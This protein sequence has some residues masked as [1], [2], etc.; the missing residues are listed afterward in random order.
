MSPLTAPVVWRATSGA[1]SPSA[2]GVIVLH[3]TTTQAKASAKA[4]SA[5]KRKREKSAII[6]ATAAMAAMPAATVRTASGAGSRN[7]S[8]IALHRPTGATIRIAAAAEMIPARM[9]LAF[10]ASVPAS[11]AWEHRPP[12]TRAKA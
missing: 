5:R 9:R 3:Q 10:M 7:H 1:Q 4:A 11:S 2:G 6:V 8:A 12:G